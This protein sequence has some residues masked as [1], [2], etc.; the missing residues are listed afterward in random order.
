[1]FYS[2][3]DSVRTRR[4]SGQRL[5]HAAQIDN[6]SL[7]TVAFAFDFGQE[8]LHLVAIEGIGDILPCKLAKSARVLGRE[9]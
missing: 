5:S 9:R 7:D 2:K 4:W 1:M 8:T 3:R 6:D